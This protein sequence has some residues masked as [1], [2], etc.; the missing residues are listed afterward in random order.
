MVLVKPNSTP[1]RKDAKT[2]EHSPEHDRLSH[3]S[4]MSPSL[5]IRDSGRDCWSPYAS[6][7]WSMNAR[8]VK[9]HSNGRSRFRVVVK[10]RES[11]PA[12]AWT[13]VSMVCSPRKSRQS[14]TLPVHEAQLTTDLKKL[15]GHDFG[16]SQDSHFSAAMGPGRYQSPHTG[17]VNASHFQP[18]PTGRPP[19]QE[20]T[21][22]CDTAGFVSWSFGPIRP[23]STS[24]T[25]PGAAYARNDTPQPISVRYSSRSDRC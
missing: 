7:A 4:L 16:Y 2:V 9:S 1:R 18:S 19:R 13:A 11:M 23:S 17:A 8:P 12:T 3:R 10:I 20:K 15:S 22:P 25:R 24:R 6:K 21:P 14:K 5:S